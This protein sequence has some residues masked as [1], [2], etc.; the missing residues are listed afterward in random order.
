MSNIVD[1]VKEIATLIQKY[2]DQELYQKIVDLRD[3]VFELRESNLELKEQVRKLTERQNLQD[4]LVR[5]GNDYYRQHPNKGK[6]GPYC[7]TCWD[8]DGKLIHLTDMGGYTHC[9]I[10][11]SRIK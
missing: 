5:E 2:Q 1:H 8:A 4:Q 10:C 3:E 6:L 9:F 11:A 7:S